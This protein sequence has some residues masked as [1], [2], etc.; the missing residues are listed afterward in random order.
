[1]RL[2]DYEQL[3]KVNEAVWI[4]GIGTIE[5]SVWR[6]GILF[7]NRNFGGWKIKIFKKYDQKCDF[8]NFFESSKFLYKYD[9][10]PTFVFR[11]EYTFEIRYQLGYRQKMKFLPSIFELLKSRVDISPN[12]RRY[13]QNL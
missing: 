2:S 13:N 9:I 12:I 3:M 6:D 10:Q 1:M 5:T 11:R 7:I 8:H 4:D